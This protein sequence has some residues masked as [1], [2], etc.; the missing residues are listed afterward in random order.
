M[1]SGIIVAGGLGSRLGGG[2]NKALLPLAGQPLFL[3]A[4]KALRPFCDEIILVTRQEDEAD[5]MSALRFH[6]TRVNHIVHGGEERRH[7]VENALKAVSPQAEL[8]LVHDAARPFPSPALIKAAIEGAQKTGAAVPALPVRDTLRKQAG[9]QTQTISRDSL[10][11]VQTPQVFSAP[12]LKQAYAANTDALTD[13]AGLV[14]LLGHGI[15]LTPGDTRNFKITYKEDWDMAEQLMNSSLRVGTGFDTHRLVKGRDLILCGV[16]IPHETGLLG[17]SDADVA[18]H[19]LTDALLGACALG[20]IGQHFPDTDPAY[21]GADSMK[22]LMAAVDL[23]AQAGFAPWQADVTLLCQRP[24]L[25]PHIQAMRENIATVLSIPLD[26]VSVKATT[27]EGLGYIG[28]EEGISAQA[29]VTAHGTNV[30][31]K[32]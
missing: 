26:R 12:L 9:E 19:A 29:A 18:L 2:Q 6:H 7:S 16:K 10:Y 15:T 4:L 5:F 23:M 11:Q 24:K 20:D 8:V 30:A 3:Y 14:E 28:R 27:N 17:H 31:Q 13:D 1:I 22:L 21:K 32:P 25:A